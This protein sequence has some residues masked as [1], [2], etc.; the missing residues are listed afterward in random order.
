MLRKHNIEEGWDVIGSDNRKIGSVKGCTDAY[1]HIDTG[2]LGL[3]PDYFVPMDAIY[4]VRPG[5]VV[6]NVR[7]DEISRMNWEQRPAGI[8]ATAARP[9]TTAERESMARRPGEVGREEVEPHEARKLRLR[10][11][12]LHAERT[13][14]RVGEVEVTREV[15]E[16]KQTIEVPVTHEDVVIRTHTVSGEAGRVEPLGDGETIR[17]PVSEER[18]R[19]TKEPHV[20]GEVEVEKERTVEEKKFTETVR[21]EVPK[22]QKKG[23]VTSRVIDEQ[24]AREREAAEREKARRDREP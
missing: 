2:F 8:A 5:E 3:G 12:E 14:E 17:I 20:Y 19:V 23:D 18:V 21:K 6:L 24:T 15:R 22:V 7:S 11:E 10:E 13:R 16:E 1:C 9:S 4:N